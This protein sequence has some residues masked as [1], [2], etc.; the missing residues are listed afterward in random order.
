MAITITENAALEL[1]KVK[2]IGFQLTWSP[3][4]QF[5]VF[6][7]DIWFSVTPALVAGSA[8]SKRQG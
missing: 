6:R 7:T 8:K 4:L 5:L 3:I 2:L 1:I